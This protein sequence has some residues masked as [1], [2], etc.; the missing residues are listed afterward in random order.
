MTYE[1]T[2]LVETGGHEGMDYLVTVEAEPRRRL[3]RAVARGSDPE[4]ARR[5]IDAQSS[6]AARVAAADFVIRNDGTMEDLEARV[7]SLLQELKLKLD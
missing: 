6:E 5:R 4:A 7:D 2:L 1:A 3:K